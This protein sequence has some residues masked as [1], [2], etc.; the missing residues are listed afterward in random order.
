MGTR[1]HKLHCHSPHPH[2]FLRAAK[3]LKTKPTQHS[4]KDLLEEGVQPDILV[5]RTEHHLNAELKRKVAQFCN[6]TTNAVIESIDA[7]SIYDVPL[8]MLKEN[9][10]RTALAKLKMR[11]VMNPTSKNG[12][13]F[14]AS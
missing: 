11:A 1:K 12:K 5:C 13:N 4:V 2:S 10:D 14:L 6:V 8:L 3:E 7:E 9:L